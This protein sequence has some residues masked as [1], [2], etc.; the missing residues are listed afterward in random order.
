MELQTARLMLRPFH[1]GDVDDVLAYSGDH[2]YARFIPV[3]IPYLARNAEEFV[4]Q[5]ILRQDSDPMWA[6][7]HEG[8]V[9]GAIE[10]DVNGLHRHG[11]LHYGMA[12]PLW[13]QGFTSEAARAILEY[14]FRELRLARVFGR[15]DIRNVGSWR[16]LE[17]IGMQREGLLR[18]S[19]LFR[20]ELI[21]D[22]LYAVLSYEWSAS[23]LA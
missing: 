1:A 19:R 4:A 3:P 22:V 18:H 13:G 5:A 2:E 15:A 11:E 17:K 9:C 7:V 12:R 20:D 23:T 6:I 8:R 21:D 14:A 16:V 10:L